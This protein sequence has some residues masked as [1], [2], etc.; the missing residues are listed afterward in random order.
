M[1]RLYFCFFLWLFAVVTAFAQTSIKQLEKDLEKASDSRARMI[2]NF[3]LAE[4]HAAKDVRKSSSYARKALDLSLDRKH[5]SMAAQASFLIA[6]NYA[7]KRDISNAEVWYKSTLGYAKKARD[8]DLII[9]SVDERSKIAI[10]SR[11]YRR[12]YEIN[13]EAFKFFSKSGMSVSELLNKFELEKANLEKEKKTLQRDRERLKSEI[14]GLIDERNDL[15]NAKSELEESHQEL[16]LQKEKVDQEISEKEEELLTV[17]EEKE[18]AE[19]LAKRKSKEVKELARETLEKDYLL[20]TQEAQLYKAQ[21]RADRNRLLW[22]SSFLIIAILSLLAFILYGRFRAKNK[23]NLE[24][25]EKN[26]IIEQERERS[27]ELLLNILPAPIAKELKENGEASTQRFSN[28]TVMFTDF[29]NFTHISER[30]KPDQLIKE[31][32][33]CFKAFDFIISQY[34]IEKIKTIGDAYMCASGL[35]DSTNKPDQV[36]RAAMEMQEFL[37]DYKKERISRGLPYFEARIGIHTGP[38]IAG[39]VGVN[40]FAYDIW[41]ATVNIA[42]R[43]EAACEVGRVNVSE[44]TYRKI[45]YNFDCEHRGKVAAKNVGEIDMYYVGEAALSKI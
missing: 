32:H 22:I 28:T 9:K 40:K 1:K 7:R 33:H 29:K 45:K 8:P 15:N 16:T 18:K 2:I 10:R 24:L 20:K 31:L 26:K 35:S 41:G 19:Q 25:E 17:A 4:K 11:N 39:V 14:S 38:V 27:D 13:Q 42:S 36:V 21:S 3:Q 37:S 44:A 34:E 5:Y 6:K 30:L 12:A 43:L 23:A